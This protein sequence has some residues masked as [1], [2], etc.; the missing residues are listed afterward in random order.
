MKEFVLHNSR[1]LVL[2]TCQWMLPFSMVDLIIQAEEQG[3]WAEEAALGVMRGF[4]IKKIAIVANRSWI[5][6]VNSRLIKAAGIV[7]PEKFV[8]RSQK[9]VAD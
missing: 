6:W 7:L 5:S 8:E 1:K 3:K 4:S 9:L 2:T